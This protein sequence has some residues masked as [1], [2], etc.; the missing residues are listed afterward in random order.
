MLYV[1][2]CTVLG[3]LSTDSLGLA[4]DFPM[5]H[6]SSQKRHWTVAREEQL[7]EDINKMGADPG[8]ICV[9]ARGFHSQCSPVLLQY[10]PAQAAH[11]G[12]TVRGFL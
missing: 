10:A 11:I 7:E 5:Y 4:S 12:P 9:P 8:E 3:L 2:F 6:N 1:R